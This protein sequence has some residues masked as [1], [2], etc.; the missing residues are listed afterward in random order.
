MDASTARGTTG[1][2][3]GARPTRPPP[4]RHER[5]GICLALAPRPA[6]AFTARLRDVRTAVAGGARS[7]VAAGEVCCRPGASAGASTASAAAEPAAASTRAT[8]ASG[9]ASAASKNLER[10]SSGSAS[11]SRP[12]LSA[13]PALSRS[14]AAAAACEAGSAQ[15][16]AGAA[17]A[18]RRPVDGA[19]SCR[20]TGWSVRGSSRASTHTDLATSARSI[21]P[22][23]AG[24]SEPAGSGVS[25]TS[26]RPSQ[27]S[28]WRKMSRAT[29]NRRRYSRAC[30]PS[31]PHSWMTTAR[32][33]RCCRSSV[34]AVR[35]PTLG[36]ECR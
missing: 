7:S 1:G 13:H 11:A 17:G 28:W 20:G 34:C 18:R 16:R 25:G 32:T 15:A 23:C 2:L 29:A 10:V 36:S 35:T 21:W 19:V 22:M 26:P 33:R 14:S 9:S 6:S 8:P 4:S 12:R 5:V 31:P 3:G 24:I 27:T 30:S